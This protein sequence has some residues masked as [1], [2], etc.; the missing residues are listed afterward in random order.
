V[1]QSSFAPRAA[2]T[3]ARN[4]ADLVVAAAQRSPGAPLISRLGGNGAWTDLTSV[5]FLAEVRDV[6]RGLV[7]SGVQPGDRV[8]LM[9]KTRYEWTLCDFAI[10]Y[11]GAVTVPVYETSSAEQLAWI[12]EDSAAVA[13][14]VEG[15]SHVR[16]LESVS[17]SLPALRET[18]TFEPVDGTARLAELVEHGRAQLAEIPDEVLDARRTAAGP[19]DL[20]TIIYTSGTTGRP[21]GCELTHGNFLTECASAVETLPELFE[22]EDASTLLFLPLAHVFGRMIQVALVMS[23]T[24]LGH[25][26]LARLTR[27]L[28][29]FRPTFV[30]A[31]PRVFEKVHDTARRKAVS[32]G[33]GRIFDLAADTAVAYSEALDRGRPGPFLALRRAVFDRL[34]YGKLRAVLG[35]RVE[36]AISGGAALSPR[37]A[38]FFRGAGIRVLEGYGL[39]ETTAASTV[40]TARASRVGT[41]GKPLRG[42]EVRIGDGGEVLVR[43]GHVFRRY[44]NVDSSDVFTDDGW[45]R[46]GDLGRIDADGFLSITGRKKEILVTSGG[47]NVS[48]GPMED[49]VRGFPLIS[50]CMI[51]GD[52]RAYVA[53]LVTLDAEA[54]AA[55]LAASGRPAQEP[56]E[57]TGDPAVLAE[58]QK[59]ID[60][61]NATVS[62]AEAIKKFR[63]L[64]A[65]I[66]EATGHLTPTLKLKRSVISADF[67]EE[68]DSLFASRS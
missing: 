36:W 26:D 65:D 12:L 9:A 34:V 43:G 25:S 41:V 4:L 27:D 15:R 11:A 62:S 1:T 60:A 30:L 31:V 21:K 39:T 28:A 61:A 3:E 32:D 54:V 57:L 42:L 47:K 20:A 52:A 40:N 22:P 50:Q 29:T 66:S 2:G 63:I 17:G 64:P 16:L 55:W 7:A 6:A 18:W 33:K 46:T 8:G 59:A 44:W 68:I 37:L 58:V 53:A 14:F 45:F 13:C 38:H 56:A 10:W 24:R 51:V 5:Q 48:P 23:T 67:A 49:V 19:D 35:G